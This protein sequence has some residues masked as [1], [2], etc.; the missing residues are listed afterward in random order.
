MLFRSYILL[1]NFYKPSRPNLKSYF[2]DVKAFASI[3]LVFLAYC[4]TLV[5]VVGS[6]LKEGKL[7]VVPVYHPPNHI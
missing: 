7:Y 3:S 1:K 4:K 2:L 5:I 6:D